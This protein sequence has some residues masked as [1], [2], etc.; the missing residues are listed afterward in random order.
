M[1]KKK[2]YSYVFVSDSG[3]MYHF[4]SEE[5]YENAEELLDCA[6]ELSSE[7]MAW[8]NEGYDADE[9]PYEKFDRIEI[10]A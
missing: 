9:I 5:Y 3:D 2:I 1:E 6:P 4:I 8:K 10:V 7:L